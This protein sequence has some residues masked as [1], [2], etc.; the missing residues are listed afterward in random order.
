MIQEIVVI[1]NV[2]SLWYSLETEKLQHLFKNC[3]N[4][5]RVK[6][7]KSFFQL[8]IIWCQIYSA[9]GRGAWC[10]WIVFFTSGQAKRRFTSNLEGYIIRES[11]EKMPGNLKRLLNFSS[12]FFLCHV[13]ILG[14]ISEKQNFSCVDTSKYLLHEYWIRVGNLEECQDSTLFLLW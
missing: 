7:E 13:N 11:N 10:W 9:S 12:N 1:S 3:N 8:V 5:V 6:N 4:R 14:R 2:S